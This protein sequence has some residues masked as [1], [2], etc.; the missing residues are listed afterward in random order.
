MTGSRLR[1]WIASVVAVALLLGWVVY[2]QLPRTYE[3][4]RGPL[5]LDPGGGSSSIYAP[6]HRHQWAKSWDVTF[7]GT[8]LCRV[9]ADDEITLVG[10]RVTKGFR[11]EETRGVLRTLSTSGAEE[12]IREGRETATQYVVSM[13]GSVLPGSWRRWPTDRFRGSFNSSIEGQ[14]VTRACGQDFDPAQG[15]QELLLVLS[16]DEA[17]S[18]VSE[19]EI[20]YE[21]NGDPRTVRTAPGDWSMV[22]CGDQVQSWLDENDPAMSDACQGRRA[23][24]Q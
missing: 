18:A 5:R 13:D 4:D 24:G 20:D 19:V 9:D 16:A 6:R 14:R 11:A 7:G 1:W 17:G 21:V 2:N 23:R 10:V 3:R 22:A 15:F 12:A 8:F